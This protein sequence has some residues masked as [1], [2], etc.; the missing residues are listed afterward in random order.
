MSARA[1]AGTKEMSLGASNDV[2]LL[3]N[4]AHVVDKVDVCVRCCA[5][6]GSGAAE[7]VA[8]EQWANIPQQ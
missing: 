2:A 4:Q 6:A 7:G 8:G 5:A 3:N 1:A